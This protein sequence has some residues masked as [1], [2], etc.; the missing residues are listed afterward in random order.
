MEGT[1]VELSCTVKRSDTVKWRIGWFTNNGHEYNLGDRLGEIEGLQIENVDT[2]PS[3]SR[4]KKTE[5]I[6]ILATMD[7]NR[8]PIECMSDSINGKKFDEYSQFV[9]LEVMP[10]VITEGI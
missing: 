1:W 7:L 4:N 6:R 10:S 8:L 5:V 2:I 3:S 9:L